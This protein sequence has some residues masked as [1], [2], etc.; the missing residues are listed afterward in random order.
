MELNTMRSEF[1]CYTLVPLQLYADYFSRNEESKTV[2]WLNP[3]TSSTRHCTPIKRL[4]EKETPEL[5][6]KT[7]STRHCTPIKRLSGKETPELLR[8]ETEN[9]EVQTKK[10]SATEVEINERELLW[11][12][13]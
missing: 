11:N 10:L 1:I 7:S 9:T 5:L 13:R 8:K 12:K 4:S 2:L 6:R 3:K